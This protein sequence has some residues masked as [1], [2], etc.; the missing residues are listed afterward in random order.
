MSTP[1]RKSWN[2]NDYVAMADDSTDHPVRLA[3]FVGPPRAFVP[4]AELGRTAAHLPF[5]D[6][7]EWRAALDAMIDQEI[8]G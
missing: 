3:E 2:T 1:R 6:Y 7:R 4:I 5:L 8:D